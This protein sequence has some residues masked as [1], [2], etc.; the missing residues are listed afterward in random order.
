LP[1][2][3]TFEEVIMKSYEKVKRA[4][5]IVINKY[6]FGRSGASLLKL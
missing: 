1:H 3:E 5:G 6:T 2:E 4:F